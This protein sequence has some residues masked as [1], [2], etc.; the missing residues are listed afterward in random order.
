[1]ARSPIRMSAV[2]FALDVVLVVAFAALG[3]ATHDG[4]VLGRFGAG[5]AETTWPFL[6]ALAVG[7]V[8]SLAVR[9]PAAPLRTGVPVWL[10]TVGGGMLLRVV[11][12]QGAAIAFVI[13]A[14]ITLALLLIGWRLLATLV[15]RRHAR[16]AR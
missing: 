14:T 3:R 11:S 1:M 10:V 7:W 2:A 16:A 4:D 5:L 15:G 12:G 9:R 13:V 8:V 6:V